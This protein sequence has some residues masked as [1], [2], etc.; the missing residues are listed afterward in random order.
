MECGHVIEYYIPD[1][2]DNAV[3]EAEK[4]KEFFSRTGNSGIELYNILICSF[5]NHGN[6]FSSDRSERKSILRVFQ[7]HFPA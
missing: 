7:L 5:I 1:F 2:C 4:F 3:Q 6:I